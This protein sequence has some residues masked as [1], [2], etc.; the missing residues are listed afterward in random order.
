ML[1]SPESIVPVT[2]VSCA[3]FRGQLS[4]AWF[5]FKCTTEEV[6]M[7]SS[8]TPLRHALQ[9]RLPHTLLAVVKWPCRYALPSP[10]RSRFNYNIVVTVKHALVTTCIQRPPLFKDHCGIFTSIKRPPLFKD[11]FFLSQAWSLNTGF[12]VQE[13]IIVGTRQYKN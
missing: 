1:T 12:T 6:L 5:G 9:N 4:C 2:I 10:T 7:Y 11:H 13:C 3:I 8:N